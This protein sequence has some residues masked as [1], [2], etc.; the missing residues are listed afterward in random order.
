MFLIPWSGLEGGLMVLTG[1]LAAL[2]TT[3]LKAD[4]VVEYGENLEPFIL[5]RPET[6]AEL[7]LA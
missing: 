3:E 4:L 2:L 5:S 6:E 7:R 1:G